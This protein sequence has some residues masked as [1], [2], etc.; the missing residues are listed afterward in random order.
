MRVGALPHPADV[1]DP[2]S[3]QNGGTTAPSSPPEPVAHA[4]GPS[5]GEGTMD[6]NLG[7]RLGWRPPAIRGRQVSTAALLAGGALLTTLGAEV[8]AAI[9]HRFLPSVPGLELG[10][11]FGPEDGESLTLAVLGDSSVAGVG[12]DRAEDTICH[13]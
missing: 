8:V 13:R 7:S 10:G 2:A 3:R 5:P 6:R 1:N 11:T 9:R 4:I 12:A